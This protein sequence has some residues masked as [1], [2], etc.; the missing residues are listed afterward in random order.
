[1]IEHR[2]NVT[3]GSRYWRT[4]TTVTDCALWSR[5]CWHHLFTTKTL[6]YHH[7]ALLALPILRYSLFHDRI[8]LNGWHLMAFWGFCLHLLHLF[9]VFYPAALI[10]SCVVCLILPS[11][12]VHKLS[13]HFIFTKLDPNFLPVTLWTVALY[14]FSNDKGHMYPQSICH[15]I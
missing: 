9:Q 3:V 7:L 10:S 6:I 12:S 8:A 2:K 5:I 11:F 4:S 15:H 14:N 13:F 1:M